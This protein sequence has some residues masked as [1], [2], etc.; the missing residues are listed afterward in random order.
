MINCKTV[1]R[2]DGSNDKEYQRFNEVLRD[3]FPLVHKYA[4][5]MVFGS[6]CIIYE[7][8][9]KC[10][11][12]NIMLMSHHDVVDKTPGWST[13]PFDATV[14]DGYLYGRGTIDTK[15]PLFA[16]LEALEEILSDN[17]SLDHI[18][19]YI[20][21]S[22]NEEVSGDG[23]V[24]AVKYF[25]EHNTHFDI[26]LD[27]GGAIMQGM[28]PGYNGKSA[29]IAV[30]EKSR[31]IYECV[32][33]S[34]AK[35]HG[36]LIANDDSPLN[37]MSEFINEVNHQKIYEDKFYP[38][39]KATFMSHV[40]YMKYPMKLIF[41]YLDIFAPVVKRIML[42]MPAAKPMLNTSIIF[43]TFSAGDKDNP[44]IKAKEARCHMFIRCIREDDLNKGLVKIRDIADKY[45]IDINLIER[46]Y[47]KP[48]DFNT[49]EYNVLKKVINDNF[50]DVVVAPFLLTAGTD[51]RRFTD[52]ADNIFRFAPIDLN[53]EQFKSIHGDNECININ[54]I[55]ECVRFYKEYIIINDRIM[56]EV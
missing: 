18:N 8:K 13:D 23:M 35:G 26:V 44:Q 2:E 38:E 31:H 40:P 11:R 1:F 10:A 29:M 49:D 52:I 46:D 42:K 51:A 30:H 21:S 37:R 48:T 24:E 19:L 53:N 43:T 56:E 36:G 27:E 45:D 16:E 39:V 5:K 14:K 4:N 34:K 47:A 28:I 9:G 32:T 25:R 12:K 6:G 55:E 41:K 33:E 54:N 22:N 3:N 17:I 50:K 7:L 20:G 15:T